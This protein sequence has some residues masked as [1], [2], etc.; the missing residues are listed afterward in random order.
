MKKSIFYIIIIVLLLT[1]IFPLKGKNI[2]FFI[3]R[4]FQYFFYHS[5]KEVSTNNSFHLHDSELEICRTENNLL[6]ESLNFLKQSGDNFILSNVVGRRSEAG[7]EWF[8]LDRGA[9]HG[10][11]TGLAVVDEKGVLVGT[12]AKVDDFI[13][14]LSPIFNRRSLIAADIAQGNGIISGIVQ[15]EYGLG[16]KMKYIPIDRQINIGDTVI[17]SGLEENI[18]RGI[19]I[20]QVT[21]INKEPNAIFQEVTIKPFFNPDFRIISILIP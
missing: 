17:T 7:V 1:I 4:P 5:N 18:R 8:L 11:K 9:R 6:R 14:Y 19:I 16:V 3:L 21:E 13:A 2:F 20:G 10:L 12:I 15:G